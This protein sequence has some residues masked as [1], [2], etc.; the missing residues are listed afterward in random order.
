[1]ADFRV[2]V[3][4]SPTGPTHV[5]TAYQALF[6]WAFVRRHGGQFILRIED[7]DQTRSRAEYEQQLFQALRWLELEWDEGPQVGGPCGPYR[8]SER[9]EIYRRY[10]D[11]LVEQGHAYPCFCTAERLDQMRAQQRRDKLPSGYDG[12]CRDLDAATVERQLAQGVPHVVRLKVPESGPVVV[13][14]TLRGE[15]DF[16][17]S[18]I[19]DQVLL[20][21]DGFPTYHMAVVVDD[22]LMEISHII[23]GEEW[24]NST[25]KHLFLYECFGWQPPS[26]TH[27]PLLLNPDGSKMSKRRNPTSVQ[28]YQ[29]AGYLAPALLNYLAL[30]AYPPRGEEEKFSL[31]D[32]SGDFDLGRINLGGSVFDPEKLTWLNGRYIRE[33]LSDEALLKSL[34]DWLLNDDYLGQMMPLMH[35]RMETLGDFVPTTSFLLARQVQPKVEDLVPKKRQPEEVSPLLQTVIW[36]LDEG[37]GGRDSVEAAIRQVAAFWDWPIRDVTGPLFAAIMGQ[38]V[39]PPLFESLELLGGDM[40]RV[41]IMA[42]ME[43]LGGLSKKKTAKLEKEWGQ[44]K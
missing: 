28:Y 14:D 6:N 18:R 27:L 31:G 1:M 7:T 24:I 22:H 5:G 10:V 2:R 15:I 33:E 40:A 8:Q 36:A 25:P 35:E 34:K 42:A 37:D 38:R 30:M 19:D 20:K 17:F 44:Q 4:P 23:R 32:F 9:L 39:G 16:D 26:F 11:Q 29:K 3:A 21:S 43:L 13:S 12:H 41:R